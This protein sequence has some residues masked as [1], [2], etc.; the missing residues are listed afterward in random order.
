MI[1]RDIIFGTTPTEFVP[2]NKNELL[3]RL[4]KGVDLSSD[5]IKHNIQLYSDNVKYRYAYVRIPFE[6]KNDICYFENEQVCSSALSTVLNDAKEVILLSVTAGA[7]IDKL[8]AKSSIQNPASTFYI[9]AIASA[10][11]ESYIDYI[12][13]IICDGLNVTK[14]FSPGYADFSL[15]FQ[16]YLLRRLDAKENIGIMLSSNYLMIPMKSITAVIGIK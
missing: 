11:V 1:Y 16:E 13:E 2:T 7:E 4:G 5:I 9:D 8:I 10:G 3:A 12:S 14:R 6:C 15:E